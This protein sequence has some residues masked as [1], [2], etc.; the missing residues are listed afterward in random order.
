MLL[1]AVIPETV[2]TRPLLRGLVTN[3][4]ISGVALL[5]T[6]IIQTSK[7][8]LSLYHAI[9]IIHIL[10]FTGMLVAP[11]GNYQ[12]SMQS[13]LRRAILALIMTYGSVLLFTGFAFYI[14][15]R[16]PTF[17]QNH[18]CN[19]QIKY[20]FFFKSVIVTTGW[21]RRLWM[22]GLGISLALLIVVPLAS[23]LCMCFLGDASGSSS[24]GGGMKETSKKSSKLLA[25]VYG[26][27]MLELYEKRN[28]HLL[29]AGEDQWTFGQIFSIIQMIS[30]LNE[31]LHFLLS[32]CSAEEEE[33]GEPGDEEQVNAQA[34]QP[35][36]ASIRSQKTRLPKFSMPWKRKE[37][38]SGGNTPTT[39][40]EKTSTRVS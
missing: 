15:A 38:D 10:Y 39:V 30:V 28:Q 29:T 35:D 37:D 18:E 13:H 20:I 6:A 2:S 16:A 31:V 32:G 11:S 12:G 8:S 25:A 5:I 19:S 22:A 7:N 9:F 36:S 4:G 24:G 23:C 40:T 33:E 1:V 21:L 26:V 3:A 17:G 27:V 14:W 34:Q